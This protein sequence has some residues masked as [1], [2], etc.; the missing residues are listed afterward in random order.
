MKREMD[1]YSLIRTTRLSLLCFLS[2]GFG[3]RKVVVGVVDTLDEKGYN[4]NRLV[5]MVQEMVIVPSRCLDF[6]SRAERL[7]GLGQ[8][9]DR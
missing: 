3:E 5:S 1:E 6:S 4:V 8:T 7:G 9:R 2:L